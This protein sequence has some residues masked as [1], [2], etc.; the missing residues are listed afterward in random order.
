MLAGT[1]TSQ[2]IELTKITTAEDTLLRTIAEET[3]GETM[4]RMTF[5]LL[6]TRMTILAMKNVTKCGTLRT[7]PLTMKR[8]KL[9]G[10]TTKGFECLTAKVLAL[11]A[12]TINGILEGADIA[13]LADTT[14]TML[15][16][17]TTIGTP[18]SKFLTRT[19][20]SRL[21]EMGPIRDGG[22]STVD[23]Q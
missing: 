16:K 4:T 19:V 12:G 20:E 22:V 1:P 13:V 3:Y 17:I 15:T 14:R 18:N 8:R 5:V 2:T 6:S 23:Q 9:E 21:K 7:E 10:A 11:P